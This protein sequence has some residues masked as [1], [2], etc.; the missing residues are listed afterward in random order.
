MPERNTSVFILPSQREKNGEERLVLL[1]RVAL[2]V[3]ESVR[4]EHTDDV[5]TLRGN[6]IT[7][8]RNSV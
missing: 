5:F 3:I 8:T 2:A 1:I 7:M 6:P 4:D